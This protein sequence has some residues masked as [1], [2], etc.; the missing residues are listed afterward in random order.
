M[1]DATA[2]RRSGFWFKDILISIVTA[3]GLDL[4]MKELAKKGLQVGAEKIG[5][6][7][8]KDKRATLLED[9]R[10]MQGEGIDIKNLLRRHVQSMKDLKENRLVD[11]LCKICL[12]EKDG[13]RKTLK[14][15][16]DLG[17]NEFEQMLYLLDHDVLLQWIE[18]ARRR[19][20]RIATKDLESLKKLLR[21]ASG[22]IIAIDNHVAPT[23]GRFAD[24]LDT[25]GGK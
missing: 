15:L 14:W 6:K 10:I 22:H 11:L 17:D 19:G 3:L 23:L 7:V 12:D 21:S 20:G 2:P 1:A 4:A 18:Q 13:R 9:L 25:K 16:N 24:W 5:E 8:F